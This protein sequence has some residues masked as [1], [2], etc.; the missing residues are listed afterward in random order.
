MYRQMAIILLCW[1]VSLPILAGC[2]GA[3][4]DLTREDAKQ[5]INEAPLFTPGQSY[6]H[7]LD[8][9][10]VGIPGAKPC[11]WP[12]GE[13][14]FPREVLEV[15]GIATEGTDLRRV[16]F[17]WDWQ[18]A[19]ASPAAAKCLSSPAPKPAVASP[20]CPRLRSCRL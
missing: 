2:A 7:N 8:A 10:V 12:S 17:N 1:S 9:M 14:R 11:A 5:I 6:K 20:Y 4:G 16:E 3:H 13:N 19:K 15:T 18:R